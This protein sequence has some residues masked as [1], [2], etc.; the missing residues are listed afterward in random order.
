[1]S[2][3]IVTSVMATKGSLYEE[4]KTYST[5]LDAVLQHRYKVMQ[6]AGDI[7][8]IDMDYAN[9]LTDKINLPFDQIPFVVKFNFKGYQFKSVIREIPIEVSLKIDD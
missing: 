1:M 7:E 9:E 3:Y 5:L 6:A 4:T 8:D 2:I